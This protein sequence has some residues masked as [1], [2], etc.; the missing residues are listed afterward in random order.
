MTDDAVT[1]NFRKTWPKLVPGTCFCASATLLKDIKYQLVLI[2]SVENI[3]V[4]QLGSY[5]DWHGIEVPRTRYMTTFRILRSMLDGG[6]IVESFTSD[7]AAFSAWVSNH[8]P[9]G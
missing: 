2:I 5:K 7:A 3:N 4:E 6:T 8:V 1:E 9:I